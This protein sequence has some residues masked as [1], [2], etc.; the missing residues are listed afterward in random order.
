MVQ[1]PKW[2]PLFHLFFSMSMVETYISMLNMLILLSPPINVNI[3]LLSQ[4]LSPY[5]RIKLKVKLL[6]KVIVNLLLIS[7]RVNTLLRTIK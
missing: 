4:L 3:M 2:L 7:C 6:F 5:L 1:R